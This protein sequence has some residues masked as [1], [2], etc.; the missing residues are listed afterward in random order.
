MRFDFSFVSSA[1]DRSFHWQRVGGKT[2]G[3]M[4]EFYV[5][6]FFIDWTDI[7]FRKGY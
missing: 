4:V 3:F 5:V 6:G 7:T 2:T 1:R